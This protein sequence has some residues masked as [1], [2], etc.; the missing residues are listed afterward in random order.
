[1][2]A[3]LMFLLFNQVVL[4]FDSVDQTADDDGAEDYLKQQN[5]ACWQGETDGCKAEQP[6]VI[7]HCL[8]CFTRRTKRLIGTSGVWQ[9]VFGCNKVGEDNDN[10]I[11]SRHTNCS[12]ADDGGTLKEITV[13]CQCKYS[14]CNDGQHCT[15]H[16]EI[17]EI[18][19]P[20]EYDELEES[21]VDYYDAATEYDPTIDF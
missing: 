20:D 16:P 11:S 12:Q 4:G 18:C 8:S 14:L 6:Q 10:E 3:F 7:P 17:Y 2:R 9:T 5:I 21:D 13:R 1:M 15:M 19:Q